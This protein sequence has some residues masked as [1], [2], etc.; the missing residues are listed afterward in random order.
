[1]NFIE[2]QDNLLSKRE[3]TDLIEW[4]GKNKKMIPHE[5][6][7]NWSG[8]D[9]HDL[10]RIGE[11]HTLCFSEVPLRPAYRAIIDLKNSYVKRFPEANRISYWGIQYVR[12]KLSLIHI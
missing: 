1:M 10:M 5:H 12:F 2:V 3:C 9:Y 11:D 4:V 8:Y 7:H 6:K